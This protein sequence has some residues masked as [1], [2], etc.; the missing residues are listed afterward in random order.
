MWWKFSSWQEDPRIVYDAIEENPE[1]LLEIRLYTDI[2]TN[3]YFKNVAYNAVMRAVKKQG[4]VLRHAPE[5]IQDDRVIVLAAVQQDSEALAYASSRLKNDLEVVMAAVKRDGFSV[6]FAG[7]KIRYEDRNVA[8]AAVRQYGRSL[9]WLGPFS[10]DQEVVLAA[11]HSDAWSLKFAS[12]ELAMDWHIIMAAVLNDPLALK[13]AARVLHNNPQ[14]V[15]AKRVALAA[16][17]RDARALHYA[18]EWLRMDLQVVVAA[19]RQN[20]LALQLVSPR[21][22][23]NE[24]FATPAQERDLVR[25]AI[26]DNGLTLFWAPEWLRNDVDTVVEA[27]RENPEALEF[28]SPAVQEQINMQQDVLQIHQPPRRRQENIRNRRTRRALGHR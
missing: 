6:R 18:P 15:E 22:W 16:V 25:I 13:L 4:A 28:A 9:V 24:E 5:W 27:M 26:R 23:N 8:L 19:V 3:L 2:F 20:S 1:E 11:V 10:N 7:R 17:T 12:P 14:S 21:F